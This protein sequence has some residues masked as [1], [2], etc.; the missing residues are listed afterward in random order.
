MSAHWIETYKSLIT[1]ST[2]GFKF[3]ALINGGAAVALLSYLGNIAGKSTA[4]M[5]M[6]VPMFAFLSGLALCGMSMCFAYLT[7]LTLLNEERIGADPQA[8][9]NHQWFLRIAMVLFVANLVA[10]A[11]GAWTAVERFR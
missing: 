11:I 5:D 1:I 4:T 9:G 3:S 6:R 10:F 2:E 7:Q 8:K